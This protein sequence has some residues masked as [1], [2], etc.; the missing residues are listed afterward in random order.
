MNPE[1]LLLAISV[2]SQFSIVVSDLATL[3]TFHRLVMS[4]PGATLEEMEAEK[5]R[6]L[7]EM[8]SKL[9][10]IPKGKGASKESMKQALLYFAEQ[11]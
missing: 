11:L 7:S 1:T 5:K 4:H 10:A 8:Q 6:L 9:E 2:A 3:T